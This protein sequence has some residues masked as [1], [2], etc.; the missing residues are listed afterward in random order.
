MPI[1]MRQMN[2]YLFN[3]SVHLSRSEHQERTSNPKLRVL[4]RI[5]LLRRWVNKDG[6]PGAN[7]VTLP[8]ARIRQ[9]PFLFGISSLISRLPRL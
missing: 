8:T 2:C 6:L 3:H 5:P 1:S 7:S 4:R 9:C